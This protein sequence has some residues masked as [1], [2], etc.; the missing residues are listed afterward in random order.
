MCPW[1]LLE[2]GDEDPNDPLGHLNFGSSP[3]LLFKP[4][5]ADDDEEQCFI[6]PSGKAYAWDPLIRLPKE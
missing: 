5:G 1:Q 6:G 2:A 4:C 3:E